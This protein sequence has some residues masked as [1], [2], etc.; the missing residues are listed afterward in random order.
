MKNIIFILLFISFS[1]YGQTNQTISKN[2]AIVLKC[3]TEDNKH[4]DPLV[5]LFEIY[6]N[7]RK[8]IKTYSNSY[9]NKL[10]FEHQKDYLVSFEKSGYIKKEILVSTKNISKEQ[11]NE[12]LG[13]F[14]MSIRLSKQPKDSIVEST[15]PVGTIYYS[16]SSGG[17]DYKKN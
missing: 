12:N 4:K 13:K 5:S 17:F 14:W 9:K 1:S 3:K 2:Y 7:E 11:W 8:L 10:S 16:N 15:Q 6:N